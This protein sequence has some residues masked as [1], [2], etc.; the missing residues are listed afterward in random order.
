MTSPTP[1]K[2]NTPGAEDEVVDLCR[3]LIR[4]DT[5][6][7]IKPER[8]AAEYVA[9]KLADVGLA[10]TLIESDPGRASV[11]ARMEGA[12][13]N[14][15]ALLVH[16]HLD[17]VPAE[18]AD[19]TVHPFSGEIQD[20]CVWGRGA[21]DM[22]NM[23]AMTLAVVRDRMRSG[24]KPPRD[25]VL[26]F[27][28]DEEAGGVY[29]AHHLVDNH[30]DLFDGCTEAIS[31]VGGFSWSVSDD[32][33]L[34]LIETAEK[35]IAWLRL[36]AR[37]RAGH[38]SMVNDDNAVT[39]LAEAVARLGR[40]KFPLRLIPS[41]RAFLEELAD[42][43]HIDFDPDDPERMLDKLGG[44]ARVVGATLRDT[45]NPS[46][47]DA[48]YKVN[49]IP[50]TATAGVDCRFLPGREDEFLIELDEVV[51]PDV[52]R[53]WI[54]H[55]IAVATEFTGDLVD[56][57]CAALRAEDSGARPVPYCLSGGTDAKSFST[58]GMT[59]FGFSP[60]RLPPDLDFTA[61]FHGVDERVP[62]ESLRFGVRVLDRFLD[63]C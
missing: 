23:D 35:G 15:P 50:Q 41:V 13:P 26:A 48:G 44:L 56:A 2:G 28:A 42:A 21:V 33:R 37:G 53:E 63:G 7:P 34:Y 60:L 4:I 9:E 46:M 12:D 20:G 25:V 55:N 52:E 27:V 31:E 8:P 59:C 19:W 36:K 3:D 40:H 57:M 49:V 51:G 14:R 10:P 18:A 62:V 24:R 11:V 17:V 5:S 43:L 45:A 6:N 38:G 16:G 32:V 58:L 39:T 29:G 54:H 61:M 22:K 30:P 1:A 47:L